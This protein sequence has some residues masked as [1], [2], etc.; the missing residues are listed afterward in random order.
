MP[1]WC[2]NTLE[3]HHEDPAMIERA[4]KAFADGKLLNEFVTSRRSSK[5]TLPA[6]LRFM[7]MAIGMTTVSMSGAPSGMWV[8]M[9]TTNPTRSRPTRSS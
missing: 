2:N 3:L 1:N 6:T 4:K 8:V 9:T 7:A 5:K